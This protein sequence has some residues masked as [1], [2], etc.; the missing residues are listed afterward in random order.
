MESRNRAL[1][2][3]HSFCPC[4]LITSIAGKI[5][6]GTTL[7]FL[8]N[9]DFCENPFFFKVLYCFVCYW[10]HLRHQRALFPGICFFSVDFYLLQV[11]NVAGKICQGPS[12][13][14]RV[15]WAEQDEGRGL[16]QGMSLYRRVLNGA[17]LQYKDSF[18]IQCNLRWCLLYK[19]VLIRI[20]FPI[21]GAWKQRQH[22]QI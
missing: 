15:Q 10:Q 13:C 6:M 5:S 18:F 22:C 8:L 7:V 2:S 11:G 19:L 1:S 9:L 14:R 12:L 4:P 21:F 20:G 16:L 3:Q 17:G